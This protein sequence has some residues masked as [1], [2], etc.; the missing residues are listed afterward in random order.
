MQWCTCERTNVQIHGC[1]MKGKVQTIKILS[2]S[3]NIQGSSIFFVGCLPPLL[4][5]F[6]SSP[7]SFHHIHQLIRWHIPAQIHKLWISFF[8]SFCEQICLFSHGKHAG[9]HTHFCVHGVYLLQNYACI[10]SR[11][12]HKVR[13]KHPIS[14]VWSVSF[15]RSTFSPHI[16]W[17]IGEKQQ[18]RK[19]RW[20]LGIWSKAWRLIQH[21]K[22]FHH[23]SILFWHL[24]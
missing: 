22:P 9:R 18:E 19:G 21:M 5:V 12:D 20:G 7:L 24:I 11:V 23:V 16:S 1:E 14:F 3:A 13:S 10:R 4:C 17:E 15:S 2:P 8:F 6:I